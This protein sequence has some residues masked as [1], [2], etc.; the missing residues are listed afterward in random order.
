MKISRTYKVAGH[1]FSVYGERLC[2]AVDRIEGFRPFECAA[3]KPLFEFEEGTEAPEMKQT[4]YTFCYEDVTGTFGRW[5]EGFL[6]KL[7]PAAE[8]PLYMWVKEGEDKAMLHGNWQIRLY[9]FA[10]W[11][12]LGLMVLPSDTVAIHGSCIVYRNRAYLFLGE[13]G[14]GKSTHTRLWRENIEGAVLLNDDSPVIRVED[15]KV[16]A[17]GSPWSGK[18][19]CYK[20]E[21]YELAGCVR[22]SQA[23]FNKMK[24][25]AILQAYGAIHPS[26]PPEFA[27]DSMLYDMVS[28]FIGK[29]LSAVPIYHL[30]CLPD[31][32]AAH[33]S[34]STLLG[35]NYEKDRQ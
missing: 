18:T 33:L 8:K 14:T 27:Y 15:G 13:S 16:W 11:V 19:P 1:C 7:E 26:C 29:L 2:E 4:Q 12:G 31:A 10:L 22:L 23:P 30:A 25:L 28:G 3:G 5:D 21:R 32:D 20:N 17:Y 6:L 9:R 34:C 35:P 24:R